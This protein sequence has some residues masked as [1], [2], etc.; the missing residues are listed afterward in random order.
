MKLNN[1]I[2]VKKIKNLFIEKFFYT[3]LEIIQ[4]LS[5]DEKISILAINNGLNEMINNKIMLKDRYNRNGYI[6]NIDELY[7]YQPEE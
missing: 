2:I 4:N 7:I 6:I 5:I 1:E 3:K